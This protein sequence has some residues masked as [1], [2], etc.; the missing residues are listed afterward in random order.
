[1]PTFDNTWSRVVF[2]LKLIMPM[3]ALAVLSTLFLFSR[4]IGP[5]G[6]IPFSEVD[7]EELA[8]E[9]RLGGAE[10]STVTSDGSALTVRAAI[11]RPGTDARPTEAEDLTATYKTPSGLEAVVTA[12]NGLFET[13]ASTLTLSGAVKVVL[14]SGYTVNTDLLRAALDET[15]LQSPGA[16]TAQGPPGM[17]EAGEMDLVRQDQIGSEVLVFKGGVRLVYDPKG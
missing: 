12:A 1:M 3:A 6:L 15:R 10:L 11:A 5:E 16:V 7:V 9:Q 13:G 17:I 2:W 4:T 8:R 14:S